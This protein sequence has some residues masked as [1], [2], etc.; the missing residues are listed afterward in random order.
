MPQIQNLDPL[1][2]PASDDVF[3]IVD[4]DDMETKKI[5]KAD[6]MG[7]TGKVYATQLT[8]SAGTGTKVISGVGFKAKE[9]QLISQLDDA[10]RAIGCVGGVIN[11]GASPPFNYIYSTLTK[12]SATAQSRTIT[13]TAPCM[14]IQTDVGGS[15]F[16]AEC[17]SIDSNGATFNVTDED[18]V[19][20]QARRWVLIFRG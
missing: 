16:R 9:I 20:G 8:F 17:T 19:W 5:T 15:A 10:T 4:M 12:V 2:T 1:S 14:R 18:G 13:G 3:P 6:F 7:D 11:R